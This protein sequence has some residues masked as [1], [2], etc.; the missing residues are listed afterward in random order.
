MSAAADENQK[1]DP[2]HSHRNAQD[3]THGQPIGDETE[4]NIR[5]TEKLD[6]ETEDAITDEK[7]CEHLSMKLR[8]HPEP[9][10]EEEEHWAFK[11]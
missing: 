2:R 5:L 4:L 8:P 10:Q 7:G 9:P 11:E 6:D 1:P 3:L